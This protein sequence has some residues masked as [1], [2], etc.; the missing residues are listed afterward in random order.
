MSEQNQTEAAPHDENK[1]MAERREKLAKLRGG[2]IAFPNDFVRKDAMHALAEA[3][4]ALDKPALEEKKVEVAV[5][6]GPGLPSA[7]V[8]V[9]VRVS[10]PSPRPDRSSPVTCWLGAVIVPLPVTGVPPPELVMV[11]L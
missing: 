2:G 6:G 8:S 4:G 3:W 1:I 5:A 10:M 11:K 7:S 9:K